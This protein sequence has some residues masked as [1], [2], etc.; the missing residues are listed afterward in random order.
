MSQLL[1]KATSIFLVCTIL[2]PVAAAAQT[3]AA[4][5][6]P[7]ANSTSSASSSPA[8]PVVPADYIIGPE[9]QLSIVFWREKDLSA[10]VVVRPDGMVSL[11]LLQDIM[12][13]GFTPEQL[14]TRLV[15]AAAKYTEDPNATVVVKAIN[16]RK[17]FIMGSIGRPGSYPLINPM[18]VL[19]LLALAGGL[20]EYADGEKIQ[21]VRQEA[22]GARYLKF[23]YKEVVRQK[24]VSQNVQ[25]KPGDTI[26]V[27]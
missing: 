8:P 25:L 7:S 22:D 16:S 10:D 6:K 14:R 15:A 26:V 20:A 27:P 13:S 18:N 23:N 17:V 1:T 3:D 2:A 9:D 21:I 4:R 19:Q 11:P 24:N 12:A 5:A